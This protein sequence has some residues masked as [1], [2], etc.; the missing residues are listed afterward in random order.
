[1]HYSDPKPKINEDWLCNKVQGWVGSW[2]WGESA[3][4]GAAAT[5][6]LGACERKCGLGN[7]LSSPS[8]Q[9]SALIKH[10]LA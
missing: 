2:C 1:M 7:R 5:H 9:G 3:L 4:A 10:S 8:L 6:S